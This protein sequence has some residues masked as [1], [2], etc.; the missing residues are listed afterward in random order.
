MANSNDISMSTPSKRAFQSIFYVN[1]IHGQLP[2]MEQLMTASKQFDTFVKEN[3]S[4]SL[5]LSGG[6]NFI[7]CDESVNNAAAAFLISGDCMP[8]IPYFC[9]LLSVL[10]NEVTRFFDKG[11][12][13]GITEF[14]TTSLVFFRLS[15]TFERTD[16]DMS[17]S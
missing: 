4:D 8:I 10:T 5:K 3:K 1:D 17:N 12:F 2:R 14:D 11:D 7:G 15:A 6:D 9:P 13:A 16:A